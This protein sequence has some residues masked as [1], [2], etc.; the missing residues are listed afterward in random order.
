MAL[1]E[2]H[3]LLV[4]DNCEHLLPAMP[5]V[6]ELLATCPNLLVLATSRVRLRLRGERELP[7]PPLAVPAATAGALSPLAGLAGV[8]AVRLFVERAQA[9]QPD[10]ALNAENAAAVAAICRRLDGLPLALELAAAWTKL[11]PP[12]ALLIRLEQRLPLLSGGARDLPLRQQT[13][14]DAIAWSHDLLSPEEQILFRRLAIFNG[15]FTLEA[16]EAV[17]QTGLAFPVFA[18]IAALLDH[19]VLHRMESPDGEPRLG[20]LETIREYGLERLEASDESDA[21]R[22]AH[23]AYFLDLAEAAEVALQGAEQ[24]R[25]LSRLEAEHDNLRAA[26]RW[27]PARERVDDA[28]GLAGAI[29]FFRWVRGYYAESREQY[30][31]LL[32]LPGAARRTTA[33]ARALNGLGITALSQGETERAIAAHEEALAISREVGDARGEAFSL[34]CLAAALLHRAESSRSEALCAESLAL[35]RRLGD[36]WGA[37]LALSLLA[38][39]AIHQGDLERAEEFFTASLEISRALGGTWSIALDLDNLGWL[40]LERDASHA[41]ELFE[42]SLAMLRDLEDRR[43]LPDALTGLGQAALRLGDFER[44]IALYE[45][46]LTIARETGDQRGIAQTLFWLA[47]AH[48]RQ[49]DGDRAI[50]MAQQALAIYDAIG[51]LIHVAASLEAVAVL[52]SARGE[53]ERTTR[54]LAAAAALVERI[55]EPIP[56]YDRFPGD[57]VSQVRGALTSE[58]FTTAWESGRTLTLEQAV[59]EAIAFLQTQP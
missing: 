11:L 21:I 34:V 45:E 28:L 43:D 4:L 40:A 22:D 19:S 51:D 59:A 56:R 13:M 17:C 9:V 2:R 3:L 39:T 18:G 48:W 16:A 36:D 29:W 57:A 46:S 20:M 32:A 24:V 35:C 54:L 27:L 1:A 8:A 30:E 44:A 47:H 50:G 52:A 49:G 23:A 5:L 31:T 53:A 41:S 55:G 58:E 37:Q 10:F 6:A 38:S 42:E 33:R 26:L 12:A 15:G 7:I 14:R 25:W